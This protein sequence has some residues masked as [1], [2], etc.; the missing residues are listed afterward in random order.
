M[1]E[2]L[3]AIRARKSVRAYE[4]RPIPS[5]VK[6]A[7][8]QAALQAPTAG[9]MTLYSILDITD[10]A[11]KARLAVTCDDQPF[12]AQAPMVLIFCADYRRW[13]D[14]F[15]LH[16]DEVRAP[17]EGDMLLANADA[18]IAAQNAVVAAESL[19][20]GS[21]YIGD[22]T[23]NFEIH[24]ELLALPDYVTPACMLCFGY[25]TPQQQD[26]EKPPRFQISDIVHQNRY[27]CRPPEHMEKMLV[28]RDSAVAADPVGWVRRFCAR[29]WNSAFSVEMSRSCRAIICSWGRNT[30]KNG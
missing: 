17:E 3:R 4:D 28:E 29:K 9:N 27:T 2:T 1:N 25:P 26:R 21:C 12:I 13:Y 30:P 22:I 18:I 8:L 24:R 23:E 15:R 6:Q 11:I 16:V 20:V 19:G 14:L 5:E 7:I 10:P